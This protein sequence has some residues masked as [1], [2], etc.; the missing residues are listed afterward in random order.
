MS[1]LT[2]YQV[3]CQP[4]ERYL[5][6]EGWVSLPYATSETSTAALFLDFASAYDEAV[7][8]GWS[9]YPLICP[10]C[11]QERDRREQARRD[12]AP[13]EA[14]GAVRQPGQGSQRPGGS[15]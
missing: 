12:D 2:R 8:R 7:R 5:P 9:A 4:C 1:I 14:D 6:I 3:Q 10:D 11:A 13:A 15:R